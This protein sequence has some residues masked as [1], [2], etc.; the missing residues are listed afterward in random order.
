MRGILREAA[1]WPATFRRRQGPAV[2]FLPAKRRE[3]SSLLRI[4]LIAESLSRLG[5]F[6]LVIPPT[7]ELGAR[8]RLLARCRPDLVVMQGARHALNRPE[9]Y[10]GHRIVYDMDDADFH[11]PRIAEAVTSAMDRV[12]LVLAGSRYVADWCAAHGART[13]VVW[14]GTP[15]SPGPRRSQ[16]DRPSIVAWAQSTPVNYHREWAFVLDVMRRVAA[17]RPGVRLRL[18]GRRPGDDPARLQPLRDAGVSPEWVEEMPYIRYLRALDDVAVGLSPICPETPFSRGKSFG[19]VLA[20]MDRGVPVIASNE[21]DHPLFFTPETAVISNDPGI[22][23]E[24]IDRLLDDV[25]TRQRMADAAF[26][27]LVNR[28]SSAAAAAEVDRLLRGL[29]REAAA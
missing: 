11:L 18:F 19:K 24:A 23:S 25:G 20:Y 22:W 29:L 28:L 12:D 5:W 6:A 13:E 8:R 26:G 21:A 17:R 16:A 15:I 4:Y 10:P 3:L 14:T 2:V 27:A 7:L 1:V 9:L